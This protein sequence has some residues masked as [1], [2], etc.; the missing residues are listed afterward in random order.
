MSVEYE[1]FVREKKFH[2]VRKMLYDPWCF[3]YLQLYLGNMFPLKIVLAILLY[4][5]AVSPLTILNK[6]VG[7]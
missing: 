3:V 2:G 4:T 7:F 6:T 5:F 1:I